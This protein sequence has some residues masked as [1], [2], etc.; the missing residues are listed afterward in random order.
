[1]W[2]WIIAGG[3]VLVGLTGAVL[4]GLYLIHHPLIR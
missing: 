4:I 3:F 1:M 2:G